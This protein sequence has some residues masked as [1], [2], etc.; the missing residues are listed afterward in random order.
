MCV[1]LHSHQHLVLSIL[2]IV[3]IL[4][5]VK[6][7]L[8]VILICVSWWVMMLSTSHVFFFFLLASLL[9]KVYSSF[10]VILKM[11]LTFHCWFLWVIYVFCIQI[12]CQIYELW[13][14]LPVCGLSFHFFNS[15]SWWM[16]IFN[17]DEA[18]FISRFSFRGSAF[19]I[20]S[21]RLLPIRG[22][23][24]FYIS[25][26]KFY[27]IDFIVRSMI[28][29]KHKLESRLPGEILVTSDMQMTP[30]LWQKVKRN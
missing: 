26:W 25:F 13:I 15:D 29:K 3:A 5:V 9:W 16:G 8:I 23:I 19:C 4:V 18:Q 17:F 2:R 27:S 7:Y 10:L 21:Q 28:W 24:F 1:V 14:F 6:W 22:Q 11:E 20:F 12:L 30:P